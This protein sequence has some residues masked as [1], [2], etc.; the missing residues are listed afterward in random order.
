M[1]NQQRIEISQ[2]VVTAQQMREVEARIFAAGMPVA[3][4]R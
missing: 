3:A 1:N 4:L 2:V